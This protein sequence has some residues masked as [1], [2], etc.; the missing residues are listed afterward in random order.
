MST[1]DSPV[2]A[3]PN[4]D[5]IT[6]EHNGDYIVIHQSDPSGNGCHSD[7]QVHRDNLATLIAA[8][9][10]IDGQEVHP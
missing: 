4:Q 7:V 9:R 10:R 6:I 5:E 3:V 2:V 1:T 8:L